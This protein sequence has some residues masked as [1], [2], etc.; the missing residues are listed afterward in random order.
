[1]TRDEQRWRGH[2]SFQ[3]EL[4]E[5][6]GWAVIAT[7]PARV[8][9]VADL[10]EFLLYEAMKHENKHCRAEDGPTIDEQVIRHTHVPSC[11]G[12]TSNVA[13]PEAVSSNDAD[14]EATGFAS[15]QEDIQKAWQTREDNQK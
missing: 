6:V 7:G 14:A 11:D 4:A 15:R 8:D 3:Q 13:F 1:M 9:A 10:V 12:W 5:Y 2:S